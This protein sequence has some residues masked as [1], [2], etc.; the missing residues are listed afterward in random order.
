MSESPRVGRA[1]VTGA[2]RGIGRTVASRL[3]TAGYHL[4]LSARSAAPLITVADELRRDGG[5]AVAHVADMANPDDIARLAEFQAEQ[6]SALDV[7]VLCAGVGT[8]GAV[9]DYPILRAERQLAVNYLAPLRLIQALLPALRAAACQSP[10]GTAKIIA[11]ASITGV[12]G[13]AGLAAYGASKAALIS[14]C[15][16][17][18]IDEAGSGV[19]ASAISPG[20]VD[21]EMSTWMHDRLPPEQMITAD[22]VA[23]LV[24]A[25]CHLSRNAVVPNVVLTRP[26]REL[27]R[28]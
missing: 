25:L 28:A 11:V 16:S 4:T 2:S 20:Y 10:A 1:L 15:K 3:A 12:V 5:H 21:T 23:E 18:T 17:V 24:L 9:G 7:L 8:A 26:G 19:T 6:G 13:E 27:W 22:D 14:L